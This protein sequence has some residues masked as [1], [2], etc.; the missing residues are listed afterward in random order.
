VIADEVVNK[1]SEPDEVDG[2]RD[3]DFMRRSEPD[4]GGDDRD[5]D[6]MRFG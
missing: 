5:V 1:R 2:D 6:F 3:I 4:E